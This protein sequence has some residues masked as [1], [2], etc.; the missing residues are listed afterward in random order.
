M[1]LRP[2]Q[3]F[4]GKP[5]IARS[6]TLLATGALAFGGPGHRLRACLAS[7]AG[8]RA[9]LRA[10]RADSSRASRARRSRRHSSQHVFRFSRADAFGR[11]FR[12]HS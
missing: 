4:V 11:C 9:P 3:P 5:A 7:C 10:T 1:L 6:I 12:S 2:S 8:A